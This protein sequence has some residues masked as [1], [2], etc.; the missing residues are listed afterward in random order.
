MSEHR[1]PSEQ[2]LPALY[3]Y[4]SA[5]EQ[6]NLDTLAEVLQEASADPILS[7]LLAEL[8]AVYQEI[9]GTT[10]SELEAR[11]V[12][13]GLFMPA[14]NSHLAQDQQA[15]LS[16]KRTMQPE[17]R[18]KGKLMEE[19]ATSPLPAIQN[20]HQP[21]APPR[22]RGRGLQLLAALLLVCVLIGATALLITTHR[23]AG[24]ALPASPA[25]AKPPRA[26]V[27]VSAGGNMVYGLRADNGQKLWQF[28][29][30]KVSEGASSGYGIIVQGQSVYVLINSQVYALRATDGK[31]L[32]HTSLFIQGTQQ[33]SYGTF[34]L[35]QGLLYVSG[36]VYG[37][38]PIPQ[39]KLFV[40]RATNGTIAWHYDGYDSPLLAVHHGIAY[41]V[42]D[43]NTTTTHLR[44]LRGSDG[45]QLWKYTG[46]PISV[47]ADDT[48]AY[49]YFAHPI[50]SGDPGFHKDEKSLVALNAQS[51]TVRWNT[52]IN[53]GGADKLQLDQGRLFLG[54]E[55]NTNSQI[56]SWQTQNGYQIWCHSFA[57]NPIDGTI[58]YL[59]SNNAL[60][61]FSVQSTVVGTETVVVHGT[62][63]TGLLE[64]HQTTIQVYSESDGRTLKW[65]ITLNDRSNAQ[66]A[67]NNKLFFIVAERHV[68]AFDPSGHVVWSYLN[69]LSDKIDSSDSF[70]VVAAGSW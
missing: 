49:V 28:V 40:L 54:E 1:T 16:Q 62:P 59:A 61:V 13:R 42:T 66:T 31:L 56:C 52:P 46:G 29:A 23:Q 58:T 57:S 4:I 63:E 3:R 50:T 60:Y 30:P 64:R 21:P 17:D 5:L 45:K 70:G 69:P 36:D 11:Q 67:Y 65:K 33:D 68:W 48:T 55:N 43:G 51:G 19:Q 22:K 18:N 44:A 20:H 53:S 39:G 37:D 2:R 14:Q 6:G 26:I 25:G 7:D 38:Q 9:D 10:V 12:L 47:V 34:L 41:V 15:M 27:A 24:P 32:W 35:D 8:D